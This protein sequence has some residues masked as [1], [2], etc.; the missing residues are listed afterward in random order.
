MHKKLLFLI[1]ALTAFSVLQAQSDGSSGVWKAGIGYTHNFPGMNGGTFAGEYIFPLA[2]QF[3]GG[4]GAKYVDLNGHPRTPV[5]GEFVRAATIDFNGY[6][7]PFR[8]DASLLRIGLGYSFSFYKNKT[9]YPLIIE[10]N[11]KS[12]TEWPYSKQKGTTTG[13]NL[14][15][16]YE[17]NIPNSPWSIG[18]RG[19]LYKAV[20]RTYFIGPMLGFQ[21]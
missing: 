4:I 11:G 10:S 9:A 16:D 1:A 19:A 20:D 5:V 15:V 13:I 17:Y 3:E 18:L 6:W 21:W 7:I 2:G 12:T 14:I 8:S